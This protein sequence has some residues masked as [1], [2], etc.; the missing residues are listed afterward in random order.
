MK[1]RDRSGIEAQLARLV[2]LD[3]AALTGAWTECYDSPPPPKTSQHLMVK[4]IAYRW[5]EEV[6][7]GLSANARKALRRIGSGSG[8]T[9]LPSMTPVTQIKP[10]TRFVREWHGQLI[11]VLV[12][13]DGSFIWHGQAY[14]SLSA[15]AREVTNTRRNGPAFFGLRE[16]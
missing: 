2:S 9:P 5:Q 8:Y 3:R 4:A 13:D 12:G 15:I 6:F 11:E 14:T 1:T 7:G 10:G 16:A